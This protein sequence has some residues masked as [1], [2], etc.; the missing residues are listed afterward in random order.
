[1]QGVGGT[2]GYG[3]GV[4]S[5]RIRVRTPSIQDNSQLSTATISQGSWY[6]IAL[7]RSGTTTR[8]YINGT[9][10]L[11]ITSDTSN[12]T[13]T[14][15]NIGHYG[16]SN[17][18][19]S[20]YISNLRVVKGTALYT[21]AFTPSTTPL[22]VVTGTSLLTCQSNR[23]ID[24]SINNYTITRAGDVSVQKFSP[25]ST[26]TVPKY[27]S[28]KFDGTGDYLTV[29]SPGTPMSLDGDFTVEFWV[30]PTGLSDGSYYHL[31]SSGYNGQVLKIYWAASGGFVYYYNGG[32]F[33]FTAN[34]SMITNNTW[35]HFAWVRSGA[36]SRL[37]IN[38]TGYTTVTSSMGTI[39]WSAGF[40]F[41]GAS[42]NENFPG[43]MSN[44]RVVKGN[45]L[46]DITSST[47]TV[48]TSPLSSVSGTSLLTC[49]SNALVDNSNNKFTITSAGDVSCLPVSPFSSTPVT[50]L[51]YSP[52]TFGSSM[53]FGGSGDYLSA[54]N[55]KSFD[56]SVG[57]WTIECWFYQLAA[58]QVQLFSLGA[59]RW[60]FDI[61]TNGSA[62][63]L[64]NTSSVTSYP[65]GSFPPGQWNHIAAT[66]INDGT[67]IQQKSYANGKLVA[68][69]Q[70][71]PSADTTSVFYVGRNTDAGSAWD[72]NG[73]MTD[74]LITK[75][76]S[77]YGQSSF[78][79]RTSPAQVTA[80]TAFLLNGTTAGVIDV[81][82]TS[83]L[84]TV[85]DTRV[86]NFSPY[87]GNYYSNYFNGTTDGLS[88]TIPT[89]GTG[90]FTVEAWAL[91]T[92]TGR[93]WVIGST[94]ATQSYGI[95]IESGY[96]NG[97]WNY[98][99]GP[100][101]SGNTPVILGKWV[102][103]ALVREGSVI[104]LY[105]NGIKQTNTATG[106]SG[107]FGNSS[108]VSIGWWAPGP[109]YSTG[110][111]SNLRVVDGTALY[112]PTL[113][114]SG[115]TP[116]TTPLTAISG[117]KILTC[118]SNKFVD[119][120]ANTNTITT[121]GTPKVVAQNPFQVTTGQSYYFDG[122]GD[123]ICNN[124][125]AVNLVE[126]KY[127]LQKDFTIEGWIYPSST[128]IVIC[129]FGSET[130]N[131]FIF[132][133]S[134]GNQLA[135]DIYLTGTTTFAPIIQQNCWTHVALTRSGSTISCYINGVIANTTGTSS[136][137]LGNGPLSI[138]V[139]GSRNGAY[140]SGYIS[141]LRIT[142]GVARTIT[143]PSAPL[144]LK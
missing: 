29:S 135:Y 58:K 43:Y 26:V 84:Q 44:L 120:S 143:V 53:Y 4:Y 1:V 132:F 35:H 41:S 102:H 71:G 131:R 49:Q 12:E 122:T 129:V 23:F 8:L 10:D 13:A 24:N 68:T 97:W 67:V 76:E 133:L 32:S 69:G 128:N 38:G 114:P 60:R 9:L 90:N 33:S 55:T 25:F 54:P 117:T 42:G 39:N 19:F 127:I 34:T 15:W 96:V 81:T 123:Y 57:A 112:T 125:T 47:I 20:G 138:G 111:I 46:Y 121:T 141:D 11:T 40:N 30:Y 72:F 79:P 115:F 83:N 113:Y 101:I 82:R 88:Y 31:V 144:I 95:T 110:Y 104:Y 78:Y 14:A 89:G 64:F 56:L 94:N 100:T 22:T 36:N 21:N 74:V 107:A 105:V 65:S 126:D 62:G 103:V 130:T 70:Y 85:A 108:A 28:T 98:M 118:Q 59:A 86:T 142:K 136:A 92:S 106:V 75:G 5:Q 52:E 77:L 17:Y 80:N 116:S 48:P 37:Y 2:G 51:S 3:L 139:N 140:W 124:T 18:V 45:A 27:Y 63:F 66:F 73:Y 50:G 61:G 99:G 134:S 119:N 87:N 91:P 109:Q 16:A 7:S 137:V 6:H 93:L